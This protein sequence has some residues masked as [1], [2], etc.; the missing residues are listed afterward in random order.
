MGL[1]QFI[2]VKVAS[3]VRTLSF[4]PASWASDTHEETDVLPIGDRE[5]MDRQLLNRRTD[6]LRNDA[7]TCDEVLC[8]VTTFLR[9]KGR[10]ADRIASDDQGQT[11]TSLRD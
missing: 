6:S 10:R 4:L 1:R 2:H 11:R 3:L 8:Q 7:S 5:E 9:N